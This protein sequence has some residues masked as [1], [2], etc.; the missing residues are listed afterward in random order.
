MAGNGLDVIQTLLSSLLVKI[1]P[2][3]STGDNSEYSH[4]NALIFSKTN[5]AL[6]Y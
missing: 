3:Y 1:K 5:S 2:G 6:Y 4:M